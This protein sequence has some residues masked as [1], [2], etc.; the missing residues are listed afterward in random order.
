MFS[1]DYLV[2]QSKINRSSA[3]KHICIISKVRLKH[4]A[5]YIINNHCLLGN[6]FRQHEVS[7]W[8]LIESYFYAGYVLKAKGGEGNVVYINLGRY[9]A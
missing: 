6:N 5:W 9:L 3:S 4:A 2:I 1:A 8:V 7:D